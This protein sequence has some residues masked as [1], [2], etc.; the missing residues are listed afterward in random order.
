MLTKELIEKAKREIVVTNVDNLIE[1]ALQTGVTF[2][3][4]SRDTHLNLFQVAELRRNLLRIV[5]NLTTYP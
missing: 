3:D 1:K 5:E 2:D 4:E